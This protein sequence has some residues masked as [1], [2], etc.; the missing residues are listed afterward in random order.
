MTYTI[1]TGIA[2]PADTG[3]GQPRK[4]PLREMEVGQSF[5]FPHDNRLRNSI[6]ACAAKCDGGKRKHITRTVVEDSVKWFR[7]WRV[8]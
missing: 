2:A 6:F 1:E 8:K 5:R 7:I 3:Q 4:Y